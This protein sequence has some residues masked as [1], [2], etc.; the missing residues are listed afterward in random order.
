VG[1]FGRR[2]GRGFG[3]LGVCLPFGSL[4]CLGGKTR[5]A[6]REVPISRPTRQWVRIRNIAVGSRDL[7]GGGDAFR[8]RG[9]GVSR[10]KI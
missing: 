4:G 10:I 2:G 1:G 7:G 3:P 6:E 9:G 8:L 5:A